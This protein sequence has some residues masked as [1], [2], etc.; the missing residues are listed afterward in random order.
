MDSDSLVRRKAEAFDSLAKIYR[1]L[2]RGAGFA[3]SNWVI[4]SE[5]ME[6]EIREVESLS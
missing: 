3:S 6:R 1:E 4:F 2:E 5:T